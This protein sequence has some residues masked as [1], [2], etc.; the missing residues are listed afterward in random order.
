[1]KMSI[2]SVMHRLCG[3]HEESIVQLLS[4]CPSLAETAYLH[5]HNLVA[6][7]VHRHLMKAYGFSIKLQFLA[8]SQTTCCN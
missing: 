2:P 5:R 8:H 7:A 3:E 6:G 1:M 4:A